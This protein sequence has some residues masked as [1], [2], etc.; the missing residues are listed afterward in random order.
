MHEFFFMNP[1]TLSDTP[2]H[3][4][5]KP[6]R[7]VDQFRFFLRSKNY[8]YATEQTYIHWVVRFIYFH[9]KRHPKSMGAEEVEAFLTHLAVNRSVSKS[10]QATALNALVC[11]YT[12]FLNQPLGDINFSHSRRPSRVPTVFSVAEAKA[13][14]DQLKG[15]YR[16]AAELMYGSGL[17][18]MECVRLRVKDIDFANKQIIVREGKGSK[19]RITVLPESL[20]SNLEHQIVIVEKTFALDRENKVGP[21]WLP[22]ALERKYP[23]AGY[24]IGWQFLFPSSRVAKDP[25]SDVVRRHHIDRSVIQKRVSLAIRSAKIYK[26]ASSH[27]FRHSFATHLLERGYDIRTVQELLGHSDVK[28]TQRYTHVLNKGGLAVISPID[29]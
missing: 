20:I 28:I 11:M 25:R 4:P 26:Q 3:I 23:S 29:S 14:I 6:T 9:N 19:D 27:T 18:I 24:Q 15:P 21:V 12:K 7:F 10:T 2:I 1:P 16:L 17:R 13:V 22:N 5:E 8:K